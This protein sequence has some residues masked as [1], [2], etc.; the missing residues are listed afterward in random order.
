MPPN[1]TIEMADLMAFAGRVIARIRAWTWSAQAG[2]H[3]HE[4]L[5][6]IELLS[7]AAHN[8]LLLGDKVAKFANNPIVWRSPLVEECEHL[9]RRLERYLGA[10]EGHTSS[11]S[12]LSYGA[13]SLQQVMRARAAKSSAPG[14][15]KPSVDRIDV[16]DDVRI[17]IQSLKALVTKIE[18]EAN[19]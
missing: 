16:E 10:L 15:G 4:H 19:S 8:L 1:L 17:G 7:D 11:S 13:R 12:K 9:I 3:V 6:E 2:R 18:A 5:N 14:S